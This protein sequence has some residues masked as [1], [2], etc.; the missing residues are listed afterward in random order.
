ML[1]NYL[2]IALR[3]FWRRKAYS[4]I[5]VLGLAVGMACCILIILYVR[6]EISY[7]RFFANADRTYRIALERKYPGR[8]T[9]YAVTPHSIS[10]VAAQEI[11]D[12]QEVTRLFGGFGDTPIRY[13]NQTF[14]EHNVI[15]AD[16]NMFRVFSLPLVKGNRETVLQK[17][18]SVVMTESTA[19]RYFGA[20]NPIGKII[21]FPGDGPNNPGD[22]IVTGVCADIPENSHLKA[23]MIIS[24]STFPF[25]RQDSYASFDAYAYVLL[26]EGATPKAVEAKLP[27][28]VEKY[29]GGEIERRLGVKF[30][31][32]QAAGNGYIYF[33]Q[34]LTDIHLRS[35]L[36][37]EL[38]PNGNI[39]YVYILSCIAVFIVLI[40]SINFMNLATARS[41][42]RAREVGIR[43]TFGS[44]R[45]QIAAQFL[46]EAAI[47]SMAALVAAVVLVELA[48]PAFNNLT[49]KHLALG[50]WNE[51][52]ILLLLFGFA[53]VVG[54]LAGVYPAVV[55]SSFEPV[56]VLKGKFR[57][58]S[59]GIWLRN[60]LVVFQFTI[61]VILIAG[62]I[63]VNN[64]LAFIQN[65]NLGFTKDW[66]IVVKN[67]STLQT[68]AEAFKQEVKRLPGVEGVAGANTLPG[69]GG[70]FFGF[71]C[72]LEGSKEVLITRAMVADD[73]LIGVL[74]MEIKEGRGFAREF[75]DTASIM[76]NETAVQKL[77]LTNPIGKRLVSGDLAGNVLPRDTPPMTLTVVG[78]VRDFHFQSLH[79]E[80]TPLVLLSADFAAPTTNVYAV[81]VKPEAVK[82]VLTDMERLWNTMG[83]VQPFSATFLDNDV[84]EFYKSEQTA[85]KIFGVF[86]GLAIF[87][88]CIGLLGL[89]AYTTSQRTKEI[90][91]RKVLGASV[92]NIVTL[93]SRDFLKLVAISIVL[94]APIAWWGMSKWLQ[95]F[96]YRIELSVWFFVTAGA[97]ALVIAL[98][99]V[100]YQA[101]RAAIANPV[102]SLRSE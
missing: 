61:S 65:K 60:G 78:V 20:E 16:S 77:G 7:D 11:P 59:G 23:D 101:I 50:V 76:L 28:I 66:T 40:A 91:I 86:A 54:L 81:R 92:V 12:I 15:N 5:N 87:V 43:K 74:G 4:T 34:K 89:A 64:Q 3:N 67:S 41:V 98:A 96:A 75:Q 37:G 84:A 25:I 32:Y 30:K 26:K 36:D 1:Q 44:L 42:E 94:A 14:N 56:T 17:P 68:R 2:T 90:G 97:V 38:K 29:A 55:L 10:T 58:T 33:L 6:H 69:P 71:A 63:V 73:D 31:D 27:A 83:A 72:Q 70:F 102:N 85:G 13:Q 62:T 21:R 22:M 57:A 8:E 24:V 95:D 18:N 49:D 47:I 35:H 100:S 53:L 39:T 9:F 88:A 48:L 52:W 45:G 79:D 82:G 19:K 99:T 80:I 93:L 51:P 46:T